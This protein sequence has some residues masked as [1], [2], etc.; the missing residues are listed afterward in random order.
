MK[1]FKDFPKYPD[2]SDFVS[3]TQYCVACNKWEKE[4]NISFV[5]YLKLRE[6]PEMIYESSNRQKI[7]TPEMAYEI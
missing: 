3:T 7:L 5:D 2:R 1:T 4:N 6:N